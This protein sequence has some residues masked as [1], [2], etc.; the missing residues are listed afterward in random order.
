MK[1]ALLKKMRLAKLRVLIQ[2]EAKIK[3]VESLNI[4]DFNSGKLGNIEIKNKIVNEEKR[5]E[6]NDKIDKSIKLQCNP[7]MDYLYEKILKQDFNKD[8]IL[9]YYAKN[10]KD[11]A[12]LQENFHKYRMI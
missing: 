6:I 3:E 11:R 4:E 9:D 8:M 12:I 10:G 1:R 7:D 2:I 5:R